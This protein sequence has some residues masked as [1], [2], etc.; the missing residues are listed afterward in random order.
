MKISNAYLFLVFL[1][2]ILFSCEKKE[3]PETE[4]NTEPN[5]IS[6]VFYTA[7]GTN[8]ISYAAYLENSEQKM[9]VVM[10]IPEWWGL[11]DYVKSRAQQ[12]AEMGYFA[13]A[14]DFYG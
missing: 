6:Q 11:N 13:M 14:V 7:E 10:I 4:I 5:I 2:L 1:G 9:P 12:S 8:Y 3:L